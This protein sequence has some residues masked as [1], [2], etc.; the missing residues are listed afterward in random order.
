MFVPSCNNMKQVHNSKYKPLALELLQETG[1]GW[2]K[3]IAL[4]LN[5]VL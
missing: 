5:F 1:L 2:L 3:L 4:S